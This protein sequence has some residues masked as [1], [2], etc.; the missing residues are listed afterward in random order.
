MPE[1]FDTYRV[2]IWIAL[3]ELSAGMNSFGD[4]FINLGTQIAAN[5]WGAAQSACNDLH[6]DYTALV[7]A[8]L[9]DSSGFK[10][11]LN[12]ALTWINDNWGG[13][14]SMTMADILNSMLAAT[15]EELTSFMGITQAYKVA[16]WDAPFNEEYYAALARGFKTWGG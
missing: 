6:D 1:P 4:N 10:G 2:N 14:G 15:F 13:G 5:N 12:T 7:R 8:K 16:V 3:N 11:K 9:C